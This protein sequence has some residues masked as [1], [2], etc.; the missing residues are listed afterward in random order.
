MIKYFAG[1][2]VLRD[3]EDDDQAEVDVEHALLLHRRR[4]HLRELLR[5]LRTSQFVIAVQAS[6]FLNLIMYQ[7]FKLKFRS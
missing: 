4:A 3:A 1:S 2:L 5:R 7:R 6:L